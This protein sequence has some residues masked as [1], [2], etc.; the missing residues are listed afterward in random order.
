M[1]P[2]PRIQCKKADPAMKT[3]PP[4]VRERTSP[5]ASPPQPSKPALCSFRTLIPPFPV[6]AAL[7][8]CLP[9][10][11]Q[12]TWPRLSERRR[13]NDGGQSAGSGPVRDG[14]CAVAVRVHREVQG[15]ED[16]RH[17]YGGREGRPGG[18]AASGRLLPVH[19]PRAA[20]AL[21]GVAYER[22]DETD[23]FF[24]MLRCSIR[25]RDG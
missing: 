23:E 16:P 4:L 1:T 8:K 21:R 9:P 6:A 13:R 7:Y 11:I 19:L 18:A 25:I 12:E 22:S 15:D 17:D 2:T 3:T 5:V 20:T 14:G 24:L 10:S